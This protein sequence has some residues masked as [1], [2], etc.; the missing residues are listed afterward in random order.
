M[1][2]QLTLPKS[3][4][5]RLLEEV[6]SGRHASIEEAILERLSRT[7]D[8]SDLLA[9]AGMD[10]AQLRGDLD[11]AWNHREDVVDGDAVFAR[12]A[13]KSREARRK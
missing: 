7:D 6:K 13:A 9:A 8:P 5:E 12:I 3:V 10:A 11:D 1:T 4:E 2:V